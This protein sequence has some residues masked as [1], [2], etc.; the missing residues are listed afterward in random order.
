MPMTD[1]IVLTQTDCDALE[2]AIKKYL[3]D[4]DPVAAIDAAGS[5]RRRR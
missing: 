4:T 3:A 5:Q 2:L 1:Q